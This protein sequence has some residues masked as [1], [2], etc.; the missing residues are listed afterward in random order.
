MV[1]RL[2]GVLP[3]ILQPWAS[4]TTLVII[5]TLS[6]L[7]YFWALISGWIPFTLPFK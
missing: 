4:F 2:T 7:H 6:S 5:V 1:D 3:S